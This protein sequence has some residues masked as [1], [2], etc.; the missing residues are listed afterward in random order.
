M[1]ADYFEINNLKGG[2]PEKTL[3][4][5]KEEQDFGDCT[6]EI[7][8]NIAGGGNIYYDGKINDCPA[9]FFFDSGAGNSI[10]N[11]EFLVNNKIP[12]VSSGED[13]TTSYGIDGKGTDYDEVEV[14]NV[15][16][17]KIKID[18]MSFQMSDVNVLQSFGMKE[19][20]CLLG[21]DFLSNYSRVVFD[22]RTNSMMLW[23]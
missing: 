18:K 22:F 10:I 12:F 21:M 20:T 19:N 4:F 6:Y 23:E 14:K 5:T 17:G 7:P 1:K 9:H 11:K 8:F 15:Q 16:I 2:D 3:V 13:K